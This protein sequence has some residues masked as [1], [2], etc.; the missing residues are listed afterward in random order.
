LLDSRRKEYVGGKSWWCGGSGK[1]PT[2]RYRYAVTDIGVVEVAH[3]LP[4]VG[5]RS[6]LAVAAAAAAAAAVAAVRVAGGG[7]RSGSGD[8]C[9]V[10]GTLFHHYS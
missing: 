6:G 7:G 9:R 10:Q 1:G 8:C 4:T 5:P 3:S 2:P